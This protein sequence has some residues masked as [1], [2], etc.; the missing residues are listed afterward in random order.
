MI[1]C[2]KTHSHTHTARSSSQTSHDAFHLVLLLISEQLIKL[3]SSCLSSNV[4]SSASTSPT[5]R[6]LSFETVITQ[7]WS[8]PGWLRKGCWVA[9]F[10]DSEAILI[11]ISHEVSTSQWM[12]TSVDLIRNFLI[13]DLRL[14][15]LENVRSGRWDYCLSLPVNRKRLLFWWPDKRLFRQGKKRKMQKSLH[16]NDLQLWALAEKALHDNGPKGY[17]LKRGAE[18]NKWNKKWFVLFQN[19]L[20]YFETE[21]NLKPIGLLFLEGSYCDKTSTSGSA[22]GASASGQ[23]GKSWLLFTRRIVF[24]I[25]NFFCRLPY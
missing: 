6:L 5:F 25:L 18:K 9:I 19:L 10:G 17:L 4:F 21:Q 13:N 2:L 16:T 11:K 1:I 23:V 15:I 7:R 3:P 24:P 14:R 22:K 12:A 20:F 8:H